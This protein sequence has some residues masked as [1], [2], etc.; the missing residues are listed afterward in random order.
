[1]VELRVSSREIN[2]VRVAKPTA[3]EAIKNGASREPQKDASPLPRW[4]P[5]KLCQLVE[6]APLGPQWLHEIK[7][8]GFRM[9]ARIERA[10]RC[11][12]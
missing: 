9:S 3:P 12:C 5:P 6:T 1:M 10:G 2:K 7:L 11:N 4:V 8:D